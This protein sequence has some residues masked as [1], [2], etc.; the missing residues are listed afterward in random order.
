MT[1]SD[2]L[3]IEAKGGDISVAMRGTCFRIKY[4]VQEQHW[5]ITEESGPDDPGAAISIFDFRKIAF[6]AATER[7][8]ELGW[9]S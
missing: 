5:L 8:R 4:R 6:A 3:K 7:A 2:L 1:H 9:L